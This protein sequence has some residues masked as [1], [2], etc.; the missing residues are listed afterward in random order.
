MVDSTFRGTL[1]FLNTLGVY[2]VILPFL[3]VFTITFAIL[4]KT[5][6]FGTEV[7][8]GKTYPKKNLNSLASFAIA[9]FAI[10]SA[11]VV[12][13]ITSVSANVVVLLIASVLFLM[14]V[15]SFHPESDDKGFHLKGAWSA[16]FILVMFFGL[17][18]IF[19][20]AIQ[21]GDKTWLQILFD[22]ASQFSTNV[23]VSAIV[24]VAIV[25]AAMVF[26][27]RSEKPPAA[28]A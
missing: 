20:N 16:L 23:S 8:E 1:D 5:K 15:G 9:F 2:D 11:Q 27:T 17:F 12:H 6:V 14:L 28:K 26:I 7:V 24:L 22:W 3:L 13:I 21:S 25:I 10:A 4:E 19:L 18:G